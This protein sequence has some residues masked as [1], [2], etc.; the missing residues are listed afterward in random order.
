MV[1]GYWLIALD[2]EWISLPMNRIP[3]PNKSFP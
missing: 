2:G 1:D 3:E